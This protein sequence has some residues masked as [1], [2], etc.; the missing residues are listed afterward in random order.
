M[1]WYP[2]AIR[3]E[4]PRFRTLMTPVRINLHTAVSNTSS[5]YPYFSRPGVVCS[6]FYVRDDGTVEQYVSTAFRAAA[7]LNGNA[8][9]ISIETWDGYKRI[10]TDG[11]PVPPWT[12]AQMKS[13]VRLVSWLLKTHPSIYKQQAKDSLPGAS[14]KGISY[15]RLGIDPWRV[16]GGLYY[17]KSRGKICPG[18]SRIS[19]I[20]SIY[21]NAVNG[22]NIA[23]P[24]VPET[25][26]YS[27]E[28]IKRIQTLLNQAIGAGLL[29]DGVLGPITV[30]AVK[31][32][33]ASKGLVVDGDPGQFTLAAL[34]A[35]VG[36]VKPV[37]KPPAPQPAPPQPVASEYDKS[38][39]LIL[40]DMGY[41]AGIVDGINGS[42]Q[43]AAV[44]SYKSS[45]KFAPG[46][47]ANDLWDAETFAHYNWTRTLQTAL[48]EWRGD[49]IRV[50]GDYRAVTHN[51]VLE[52]MTR[53]KG[54]AYQGVV[55]GVPGPIFCKMLGIPTHP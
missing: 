39:Q 34:T 15:H 46:L 11:Q 55:D 22:T 19:Q 36:S 17:S 25:P 9:T 31:R 32:F 51:R 43:R 7:D 42:V 53:N 50:D 47:E 6:H 33:Q 48:N 12:G 18:P 26:G 49:T 28:Y 54:T 45:Q 24:E 4:V 27:V 16:S 29:V 21:Y 44:K 30:S 37:P 14:S 5:L 1:A 52:V 40:K 3:K 10:W 23:Q 13:L 2:E 38:V 20:G 35:A 8:D 41:Y